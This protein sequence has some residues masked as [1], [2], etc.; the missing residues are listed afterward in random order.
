VDLAGQIDMLKADLARALRARITSETRAAYPAATA[1]EHDWRL[2]TTS[3]TISLE[4]VH[5][6]DGTL[7]V[8]PDTHSLNERIAGD[9][10]LLATLA[11]DRPNPRTELY[12]DGGG[13]KEM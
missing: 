2:W 1:V 5:A 3:H 11:D 9:V 12:P 10:W 6:E 8:W 13:T 4:A 7:A